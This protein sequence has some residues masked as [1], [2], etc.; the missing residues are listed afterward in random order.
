MMRN[1]QN[2][3]QTLGMVSFT[4]ARMCSGVASTTFGA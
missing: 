4:A 1:D 3:G 2:K